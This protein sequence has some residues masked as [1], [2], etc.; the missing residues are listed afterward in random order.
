MSDTRWD[1][2]VNMLNKY[3]TVKDSSSAYSFIGDWQIDDNILTEQ[4][5]SNGLFARIIDAPAEEAIKHGFSL[6]IEDKSIC[7]YIQ[8]ELDGMGYEDKFST[9]LN[10]CL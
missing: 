6:S 2:Y 8:D 7:D 5:L 10:V 4:Y 3:G 9:A 1:G